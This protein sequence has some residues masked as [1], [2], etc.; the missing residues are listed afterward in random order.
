MSRVTFLLLPL[1]FW[2]AMLQPSIDIE[3]EKP[4]HTNATMENEESF[5]DQ[6]HYYSFGHCDKTALE[7]QYYIIL[8]FFSQ[9]MA[10]LKEESWCNWSQVIRPYLSLT[11]YFI[12]VTFIMNCTYPNPIAEKLFLNVHGHYFQECSQQEEVFSDAPLEV[13]LSLTLIPIILIPIFVFLVVWKNLNC[14]T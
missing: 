8:E 7:Q 10:E 12:D 3:D 1:L 14:R 11:E 5:Q 4:L 9:R 13:V 6:E 2:G